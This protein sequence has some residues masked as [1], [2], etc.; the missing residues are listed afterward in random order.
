[1]PDAACQP[2][3]GQIL[4][5][6]VKIRQGGVKA[7][8]VDQFPLQERMAGTRQSLS[9]ILAPGVAPANSLDPDL[10]PVRSACVTGQFQGASR[11]DSAADQGGHCK[12]PHA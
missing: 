8:L 11:A 2:L 5:L 6:V 10:Q 7:E 12:E 4:N 1:M 9:K 3:S